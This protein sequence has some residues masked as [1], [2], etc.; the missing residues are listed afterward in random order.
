MTT[1]A[2][3]LTTTPSE[4]T[5]TPSTSTRTI[6][7]QPTVPH[8]TA[9]VEPPSDQNTTVIGLAAAGG[10]VAVLGAAAYAAVQSGVFPSALGGGEFVGGGE[11]E[12]AMA[13]ENREQLQAVDVG[14]FA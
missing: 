3:E 5:T 8:T 13:E 10:S 7:I 11:A 12:G 4:L 1:D 9:P 14:M 2:E 6:S